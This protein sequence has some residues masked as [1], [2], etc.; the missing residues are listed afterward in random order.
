MALGNIMPLL[1]RILVVIL[2]A[3]LYVTGTL[4]DIDESTTATLGVLPSKTSASGAMA[5]RIGALIAPARATYLQRR[6]RQTKRFL[7]RVSFLE[8]RP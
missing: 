6:P 4:D 1:C 7:R 5:G 3:K 2:S 8:S